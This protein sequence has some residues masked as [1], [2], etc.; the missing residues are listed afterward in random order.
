[1][2]NYTNWTQRNRYGIT[3]EFLIENYVNKR[4]SSDKL[5][6]MVGCE[7]TAILRRLRHHGITVRGSNE[8]KK[9]ARSK[10]RIDLPEEE[11]IAMYMQDYQSAQTVADHYGVSVGPIHRILK[12]NGIKTKPL[13]KSRNYFGEN[14][15]NYRHEITD[16]EREQR[17]DMNAQA[18][19]REE[20]Y[21]LDGHRCVKCERNGKLNAHHIF[22]H[23]YYPEK[24]WDVNNG[25]TLCV[26]CH[27]EFHSRYGIKRFTDADFREF[28]TP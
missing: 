24:R 7:R 16:K 14:S 8:T 20:V 4:L 27:R 10:N 6:E 21:K 9:G 11:V 1:L 17:R 25:A 3:E 26:Y 28:I 15:P 5:A 19:W 18:V 13:G 23:A 2:P 12:E 22:S